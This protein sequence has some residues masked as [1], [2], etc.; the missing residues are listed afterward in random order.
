MQLGTKERTTRLECSEVKTSSRVPRGRARVSRLGARGKSEDREPL[1]LPLG[2]A[3]DSEAT[4]VAEVG[5]GCRQSR[6]ET[7]PPSY[8]FPKAVKLENR[9]QQFVDEW[10]AE[11]SLRWFR[12]FQPNRGS[13]LHSCCL[14]CWTRP[15]QPQRSFG[16]GEAFGRVTNKGLAMSFFFLRRAFLCPSTSYFIGHCVVCFF[17]HLH[18][19]GAHTSADLTLQ[20]PARFSSSIDVFKEW[21]E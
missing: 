6:W 14:H 3:S 7:P 13:A 21:C 19:R 20:R 4:V 12:A 2:V 9:P 18:L 16:D 17:G 8:E 10:A 15:L 11:C 1:P 5:P